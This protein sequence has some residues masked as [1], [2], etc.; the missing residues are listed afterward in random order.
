M[1][2]KIPSAGPSAHNHRLCREVCQENP[3]H[4]P[5]LLF[6][7]TSVL[8]EWFCVAIKMAVGLVPWC[9]A[10]ARQRGRTAELW[11][12][13]CTCWSS[14]HPLKALPVPQTLPPHKFLCLS[15][16]LDCVILKTGK[17]ETELK[18]WKESE[19]SGSW[20]LDAIIPLTRC[21]WKLM[22]LCNEPIQMAFWKRPRLTRAC[23]LCQQSSASW[24]YW[25]QWNSFISL[26]KLGGAVCPCHL[27][28][29][30]TAVYLSP[31]ETSD[32]SS[33]NADTAKLRNHKWK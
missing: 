31:S 25:D 19:K 11:W 2:C 9:P 5:Q 32:Y 24:Y 33:C 23:A 26:R 28:P 20:I 29:L 13:S 12:G 6:I 15:C 14:S 30:P 10:C 16:P 18:T 17:E 1:K 22:M 7:W 21:F 3:S 27:F 4:F 8:W